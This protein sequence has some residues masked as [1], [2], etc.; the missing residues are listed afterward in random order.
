LAKRGA[1]P[2]LR[3]AVNSARSVSLRRNAVWTL[4][5]IGTPAARAALRPAFADRD[6]SVRQAAAFSAG[7][8]RD[9]D[10]ASALI[11]LLAHEDPFLRRASATALGQIGNA[12]AIPALLEALAADNDEFLAHALTF[13][14]IEINQPQATA[15][16][17]SHASPQVR[18]AALIALDQMPGNSLTREQVAPLLAADDP[19]LRRTALEIVGRRRWADQV[20]ALLRQ[21]LAEPTPSAEQKTMIQAVIR[22]LAREAAVQKIVLDTLAADATPPALQLVILDGLAQSEL[23]QL[24]APFAELLGRRLPKSDRAFQQQVAALVWAKDTAQ[25][26]GHFLRLSRDRALPASLRLTMLAIAGRRRPNLDKE[27]FDFLA[28]KFDEDTA[29]ADRLLAAEALAGATL[30]NA[31]LLGV[32]RLVERVGPLELPVLFRTFEKDSIPLTR[33]NLGGV[34]VAALAK[35]PGLAGIS[36][37]RVDKLAR[38]LTPAHVAEV[39]KLLD[40]L[41]GDR[42]KIAARMLELERETA[43][44]D[45]ARGRVLFFGKR[46]ACSTC[47]RLHNQGGNMGPDLSKIAAIRTGRDLLEAVVFPD[48][49]IVNGYESYT[50]ATAAGQLHTGLL[51]RQSPEAV[52]LLTPSKGELRIGRPDITDLTPTRTSLM[53][54]GLERILSKEELSDLLAF[55]RGLK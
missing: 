12:E 3:Q 24:P 13:A 37:D 10:A 51:A 52:Y 33:G 50:V 41:H 30:D 39:K 21:W 4:V 43:G 15:K 16:G 40:R 11:K 28:G 7:S 53:P 5:Q 35:S 9:Q 29:P 49:T 20:T 18:R 17:L 55:L 14:L 25:L 47:H 38:R 32:A 6:G 34:L 8:L 54:Q 46:A 45:A 48:A 42:A 2:A 36:T 19:A 26:D 23:E 44:G 27:L 31:H 1:V 22:A